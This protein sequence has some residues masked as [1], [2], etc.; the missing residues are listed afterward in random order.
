MVFTMKQLVF[1]RQF[2]QTK[3]SNEYWIQTMGISPM[4]LDPALMLDSYRVWIEQMGITIYP[5][6]W[7][8]IKSGLE[9]EQL[10]HV[11]AVCYEE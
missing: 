11:E 4:I 8:K 7:S 3:Q 2:S 1:N 9:V 5:K 6:S 10:K